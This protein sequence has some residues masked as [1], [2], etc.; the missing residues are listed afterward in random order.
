MYKS[1]VWQ[2]GLSEILTFLKKADKML[3]F[4]TAA[5]IMRLSP[6]RL[7][8]DALCHSWGREISPPGPGVCVWWK[9]RESKIR[10]S[11]EIVLFYTNC[12]SVHFH[13]MWVRRSV[14]VFEKGKDGGPSMSSY[15]LLCYVMLHMLCCCAMLCN[16]MLKLLVLNTFNGQSRQNVNTQPPCPGLTCRPREGVKQVE[17]NCLPGR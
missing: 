6:H 5:K 2:T 7:S 15:V 14:I 10:T 3:A 11:F 1:Y 9:G 8:Q 17:V 4:F 16:D 13:C 12:S